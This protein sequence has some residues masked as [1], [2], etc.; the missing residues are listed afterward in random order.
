M[1]AILMLDL[2]ARKKPNFKCKSVFLD[3]YD[4][5]MQRDPNLES[6]SSKNSDHPM[7]GDLRNVRD[8]FESY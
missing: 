1:Q 4:T 2:Q 8:P 6:S 5:D 3:N 7:T